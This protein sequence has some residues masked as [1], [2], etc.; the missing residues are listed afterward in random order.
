MTPMPSSLLTPPDLALAH[1]HF[2]LRMTQQGN[3]PETVGAALRG[4]MALL[5]KRQVCLYPQHQRCVGCPLLHNCV[6][7][8]IFEPAPPPER[9][10]LSTHESVPLPIVLQPPVETVTS[11]RP[12]DVFTF[13]VVLVGRATRH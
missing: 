12:G 6:Y 2:H 1:L 11:C 13:G 7:P 8:A 4:G 3:L 5:L 10:V 9:E